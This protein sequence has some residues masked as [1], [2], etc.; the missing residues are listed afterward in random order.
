MGCAVRIEPGEHKYTV[1]VNI[2][3]SRMEQG[4]YP[5]G[6]LLPSEADL[7]REFGASRSTVVRALEFLRQTGWLEGHQGKGR[8]VLGRPAPALPPLPVR[9]DRM[10]AAEPVDVTLLRV[11]PVKAPPR[12]ASALALLARARLVARRRLV[13]GTEGPAALEVVYA[14]TDVARGTGLNLAAPLQ[15]GLIASLQRHGTE[16]HS[17]VETVSARSPSTRE[18]L[19]MRIGRRDCVL[20]V[21]LVLRD[22]QD[23]PLVA[24]DAMIPAGRSTLEAAFPVS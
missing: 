8:M 2:L 9:I 22:R 10:L 1:I 12:V 3:R 21:L 13:A 4:T 5:T 17:V 16:P 14:P 15:D 20:A 24:I 18:T 19:L 6:S 11:G 23:R 7:V